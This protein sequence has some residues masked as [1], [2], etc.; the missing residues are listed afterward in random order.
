[1]HWASELSFVYNRLS[2]IDHILLGD[3]SND[4]SLIA[5]LEALNLAEVAGPS[6]HLANVNVMMALAV[7]NKTKPF[8]H[9][10]SGCVNWNNKHL[11]LY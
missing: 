11:F 2:Q 3:R 10:L 7:K 4:V 1:M 6:L 8:L 9:W 5:L